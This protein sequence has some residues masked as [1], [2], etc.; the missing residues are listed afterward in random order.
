MTACL[1]LH[2]VGP[3]PAHISEVEKPYWVTLKAFEDIVEMAAWAEAQLTFDDGNETDVTVALPRLRAAG[4]KASFFIPS[5]RIGEP[6]YLDENDI[7]TL[8]SEGMEIGSHGSAHLDWTKFSDAE[9]TNDVM[10]SVARIGTIIN[11]PVRSL[12]I[13]YGFCDRRVLGVLRRLGIGRAYSSFRGPATGGAWLVR[14]DCIMADMS[15]D[16]IREVLTHK[17]A[18]A[19]AAIAFLRI[20]RRAGN[21]ALWAA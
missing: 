11:A 4:L 2:G 14:R 7:R 19:A 12:A 3:V 17:P 1:M 8:H 6:G 10:R 9:I 20:W 16:Q 15:H 13:P 5:D 21:A 18:T